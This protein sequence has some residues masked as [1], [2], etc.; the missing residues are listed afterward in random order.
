MAASQS[1]RHNDGLHPM[2]CQCMCLHMSV[3][4]ERR[5]ERPRLTQVIRL[6]RFE[7]ANKASRHAL[8][9]KRIA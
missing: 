8:L 4:C 5:D 7:Q 2:S 1:L 3:A 9:K 6:L